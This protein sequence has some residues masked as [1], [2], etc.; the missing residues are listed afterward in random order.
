LTYSEVER[1]AGL[2]VF[3]LDTLLQEGERLSASYMDSYREV[4][5]S[6]SK[7]K[8]RDLC[9][10]YVDACDR[11]ALARKAGVPHLYDELQKIEEHV[12]NI[13]EGWPQ[14]YVETTGGPDHSGASAT[15]YHPSPITSLAGKFAAGPSN[16][17]ILSNDE[18]ERIK[19]SFAYDKFFNPYKPDHFAFSMAF[20]SL[21]SIKA[22]AK[23]PVAMTASFG[24]CMS[25]PPSIIRVFAAAV[26]L[27]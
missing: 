12:R 3:I 17:I 14:A 19:A 18:A 15:Q 1:P 2:G 25:I 23:G 20:A 13:H 4:S 8:D 10:P 26:G 16:L 5:K 21:C 9:R 22:R 27:E 6:L 7:T 24:D 11:A